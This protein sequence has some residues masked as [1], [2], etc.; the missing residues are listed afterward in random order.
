[1][2][3]CNVTPA[4]VMAAMKMMLV[5]SAVKETARDHL[6]CAA[7]EDTSVPATETL[8]FRAR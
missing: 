3:R 7:F 5:E 6:D 8:R 2:A 1:M 4:S